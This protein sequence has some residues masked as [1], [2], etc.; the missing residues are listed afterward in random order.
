MTSDDEDVVFEGPENQVV[1]QEGLLEARFN[2]IQAA[3]YQVGILSLDEGSPFV[4]VADFLDDDD[5][6]DFK[7]N[8]S[9]PAFFAPNGSIRLP[10]FAIAFAGRHRLRIF[11]VDQ[12]VGG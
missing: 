4:L 8:E 6:A 5:Y 12:E 7:R 3:G 10:W 1:Y 11:A 9:S 2:P